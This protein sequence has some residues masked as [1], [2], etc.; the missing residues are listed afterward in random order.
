ML[1]DLTR[2]SLKTKHSYNFID[3]LK[4]REILML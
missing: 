4:A 1:H 3:A 2:V